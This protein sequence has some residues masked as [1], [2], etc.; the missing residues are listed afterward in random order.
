MAKARIFKRLLL[1]SILTAGLSVGGF[2][3]ANSFDN[4]SSTSKN[5]LHANSSSNLQATS[6]ASSVLGQYDS[7]SSNNF[8]PSF[9]EQ[10]STMDTAGDSYAIITK[11]NSTA[12]FDQVTRYS[13]SGNNAGSA[14]WTVTSTEFTAV[15][16]TIS[17]QSVL[18]VDG[19][20][21]G[22]PLLYVLVQNG[23]NSYLFSIDWQTGGNVT[24]EQTFTGKIYNIMYLQSSLTESIMLFNGDAVGGSNP[25]SDKVLSYEIY[26]KASGTSGSSS[27]VQG[28]VDLSS[29]ILSQYFSQTIQ[30]KLVDSFDTTNYYYFVYQLVSFTNATA[31]N[32]ATVFRVAK[33]D[34]NTNGKTIYVNSSNIS[35][36]SLTATGTNQVF[37]DDTLVAVKAVKKDNSNFALFL[38]QQ[39]ANGATTTS[40]AEVATFS[41][42]TLATPSTFTVNVYDLP[43]AGRI[44]LIRPYYNNGSIT[45]FLALDS[46]GKYIIML[47]PT[48]LQPSASV[49]YTGT[50]ICNIVTNSQYST[51]FFQVQNG[52]ISELSGNTLIFGNLTSSVG[53]QLNEFAASVTVKNES[54]ISSSVLHK[55][56]GT[57]ASNV[58]SSFSSYLNSANSYL[59]FLT[60]TNSDVRFGSPQITGT[61]TNI[62]QDGSSNNYWVTID[63]EQQLRTKSTN[64]TISNNGNKITIATAYLEFTNA[65]ASVTANSRDNVPASITSKVPSAVT[66]DDIR[67]YLVNAQNVGDYTIIK[68]ANDSQGTLN[69]QI[70]A[71]NVWVNGSLVASQTYNLTFGTAS[72]PF[73]QV[74]LLGGLDGSVTGATTDYL[75]SNPDL[76]N[77]LNIKYGTMLP[78]EIT[79]SQVLSDFIIL[80]DAFS[81]RL[82]LSQG[83]V[84]PPTADNVSLVPDDADGTIFVTVTI[85]RIGNQQ[86]VVYSFETA[87]IFSKDVASNQNVYLA[88]KTNDEVLDYTPPVTAGVSNPYSSYSPSSLASLI[89]TTDVQQQI[90]NLKVFVNASNF[91]FN[92]LNETDSSGQKLLSV[93]AVPDD[94]NGYLT[95]TF[96]FLN[97]LPGATSNQLSQMYT[98]FA[99]KGSVSGSVSTFSWGKISN[100]AFSGK[101][102]TEV[103]VN[104][105][106]TA[107]LFVYGG[108]AAGLS[109]TIT[110]TPLNNSGALI[111][112]ITF[113]NWIQQN[114][115]GGSS[116]L[117]TIPQKTFTTV[118]KNGLTATNT[119]VNMIVWKSY[120]ELL[121]SYKNLTAS[122]AVTTINNL[123]TNLAK[124]EAIANVSTELEKQLTASSDA[125]ELVLEANDSLGQISATARIS[126]N[127]TVQT[128]TTTISGFSLVDPSYSVYLANT[129]SSVVNAL[130]SKLPSEI[131][132]QDVGKLI[133]LS[134]NNLSSVVTKNFN[135]IDGTLTVSVSILDNSGNIIAS[136]SRTYSGFATNVPQYQG[137]DWVVVVLSVLIPAIL[138]LIPILI[139]VFYYNRKDK[140]RFSKKLDK[141]LSEVS[142]KK[143][144]KNVKHIRDL[145]NL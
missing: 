66:D 125:L 29:A 94:V 95:I 82:L 141:R 73:F 40:K 21:S 114:T 80:G 60:V 108:S 92:M 42:S 43:I 119:T 7:D 30:S 8:N 88:F 103:T 11:A 41:E 132:D 142:G 79:P 35:S 22:D 118:I 33:N 133:T 3:I 89:N 13:L 28:S 139:I 65:N 5:I 64:G 100:T 26:T 59:D 76:E 75:N 113:N 101:D 32:Y 36:L 102:P 24:L 37:T 67:N 10:Y 111:V 134:T 112:S 98:G 140:I 15:S 137:T 86:N 131:T 19:G 12:N 48:T 128:F 70:V 9:P 63:F 97:P 74:D 23:T 27:V 109:K 55:K 130:R 47:D 1:V 104:D 58:D 106:T 91:V 14:V 56:V 2:S 129:D 136:T 117:V 4:T 38:S 87:A 127:G 121:Q 69:V 135:D 115:T 122:N 6:S 49:Y 61:V 110:L 62:T 17:L 77:Q 68:T 78:S 123:S 54:E 85:P 51:W 143:K 116:S 90:S 46:T 39:S 53:A 50:D 96:N 105:L 25:T 34:L 83:I 52:Q 84:V 93:S 120:D 31:N 99:T 107:G 124:L 45:G 145:L 57:S 144:N 44:S 71:S 138:L 126:L 20:V 18:Y 81:D 72:N 16:G